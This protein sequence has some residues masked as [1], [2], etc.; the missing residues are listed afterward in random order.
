MGFTIRRLGP[1]DEPVLALLTGDDAD[2]DLE[3]RGAPRAPL[4]GEAARAYLADASLL[5]WIAEAD[6][7][8]IGHMYAHA[9]RKRAGD[10]VEVLLYEIG[11]RSAHRRRGVGRALVSALTEWMSAH[12]VREA[13][14]VAD[15]E[16]AVEFYRALGFAAGDP[17]AAV[18]M[19][20]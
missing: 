6:G 20:R 17:R 7:M 15:N 18:Y 4:S 1:G 12:D 2:F 19:T 8:V 10:P 14:V 9:L 11:V 16:G 5:H 13:W 3:D